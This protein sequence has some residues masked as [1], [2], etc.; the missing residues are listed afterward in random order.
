MSNHTEVQPRLLHYC[1][2]DAVK[3]F[4]TMR[5]CDACSD[6]NGPY[7]GFNITHYCGDNPEKVQANRQLLCGL[8]G[9]DDNHLIL[10]RQTHGTNIRLIDTD[11]LSQSKT[12]QTE[13]LEGVDGVMTQMAGVCIGVSTADCVPLLFYDKPHKAVAAIH[14]GW[15]GTAAHIIPVAVTAMRQHFDTCPE[16]LTVVIGPCISQSAFEVGDEVAA[17]FAAA[18]FNLD[19]IGRKYA[20]SEGGKWHIDLSAACTDELLDAGVPLTNILVADICTRSDQR[21]FSA[22]RLGIDSGRIFNG[23][24]L[25]PQT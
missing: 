18:G 17:A 24:M 21:F 8:L 23:I 12:E 15:R 6:N 4:N 2:D 25:C 1:L 11:F 7:A 20:A 10:P 16:D 19:T 22:R 3:A 5:G 14:A 9:I 13:R